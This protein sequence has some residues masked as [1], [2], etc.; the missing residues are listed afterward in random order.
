M[1]ING[2]TLYYLFRYAYKNSIFDEEPEIEEISK[3][4]LRLRKMQGNMSNMTF[5]IKLIKY[6]KY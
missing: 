4:A 6:G 5:E 3:I 2:K 1:K